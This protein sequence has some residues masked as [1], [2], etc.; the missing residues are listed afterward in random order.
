MFLLFGCKPV[1]DFLAFLK[2]IWIVIA[3][4]IAAKSILSLYGQANLV[5]SM[6]ELDCGGGRHLRPIFQGQTGSMVHI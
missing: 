1:Y 6:A 3:A 2:K 5:E 4:A